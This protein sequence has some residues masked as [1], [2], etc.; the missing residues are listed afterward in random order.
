MT[1]PEVIIAYTIWTILI[2]ILFYWIWKFGK[3]FFKKII[4]FFIY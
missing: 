4:D 1:T 2:M 3:E